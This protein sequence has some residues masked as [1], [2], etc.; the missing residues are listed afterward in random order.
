MKSETSILPLK[1]A[2]IAL[3]AITI[4][5]CL[6]LSSLF[7]DKT[8]GYFVDTPL[9]IVVYVSMLLT[10][11]SAVCLLALTN[12]ESKLTPNGS[13]PSVAVSFLP[14]I[15]AI[16]TFLGIFG[17]GDGK[18]A[19][20]MSLTALFPI[21]FNRYSKMPTALRLSA[22]FLQAI[23]AILAIGYLYFDMT[24]E[25]NNP[26][27]VFL[28]LGLASVIVATLGELRIALGMNSAGYYVASKVLSFTLSA[29]GAFPA[30]FASIAG[31]DRFPKSYLFLAV[32]I[33]SYSIYSA[34][35]LITLSVAHEGDSI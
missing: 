14:G 11:V 27:K 12:K 33:L 24:T 21:F 19:L 29:C 31:I 7:L 28:M 22:G 17:Q 9:V 2:S 3:S 35:D 20:F 34:Y 6:A 4:L 5:L 10:A 30:V 32:F 16:P 25:L 1:L 13:M 18:I 15:A 23:F 8:N 26:V